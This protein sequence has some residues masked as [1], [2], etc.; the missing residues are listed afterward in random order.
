LPRGELAVWARTQRAEREVSG[1]ARPLWRL[2]HERGA[3]FYGDLA[4]LS[5]LLPEP[6][7]DGL[8]ELVGAG[9]ISCD[10]FGG[11]RQLFAQRT[12]N[13]RGSESRRT[14][15]RPI[16][17][18]LG[19]GRWALLQ[20]PSI[21]PQERVERIARGLLARWGCVFRRLL[22][23]ERLDVSWRD[24]LRVYRRM[25]LRGELH[26]GRFV[27]R[28]SGEQFAL[29]SAV[30]QMRRLRREGDATAIEVAAADPLN[31]VGILTPDERVASARR[32]RVSIG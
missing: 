21:S 9:L 3:L 20:A 17:A 1:R 23:R 4:Q 31:L 13:R 10:S 8:S 7:E 26:G 19:A 6:L 22:D 27:T 29:P 11:L 12:P 32:R 14:R 25:E 18:L 28:F 15:Q 30:E 16:G 5:G 24:L 2:L